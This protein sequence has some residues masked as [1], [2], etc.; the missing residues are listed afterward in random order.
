MEVLLIIIL[1]FFALGY[2][3]RLFA[4]FILKWYGKRMMKRFGFTDQG[5][6]NNKREGEVTINKTTSTGGKKK[7]TV[8]KDVGD[9]VDF[10]EVK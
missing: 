8:A 10:E 4:P 2:L 9:Y 6:Q 3:L 1:S 5:Q 7:K